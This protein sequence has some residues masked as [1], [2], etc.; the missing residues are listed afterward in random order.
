MVLPNEELEE[1]MVWG[2][3]PAGPVGLMDLPKI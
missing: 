2:G 3:I 1:R